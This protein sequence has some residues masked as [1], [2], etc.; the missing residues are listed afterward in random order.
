[1]R[2]EK[3]ETS[4]TLDPHGGFRLGCVGR[5]GLVG[6]SGHFK[7]VDK[8][9]S[10][11]Q[12]TI[13]QAIGQLSTALSKLS[14]IPSTITTITTVDL[15]LGRKYF[16]TIGGEQ[17]D[18]MLKKI[19]HSLQGLAAN[20]QRLTLNVPEIWYKN[21]PM[22]LDSL[23]SLTTFQS[24]ESLCLDLTKNC[25]AN[26]MPLAEALGSSSLAVLDLNLSQNFHI[27]D[28]TE[29]HT[30]LLACILKSSKL[31]KVSVNLEHN[32]LDD[33]SMLKALETT[34]CEN[35]RELHVKFDK[36][37]AVV[38]DCVCVC[39]P[40]WVVGCDP[41]CSCVCAATWKRGSKYLTD[42]G[43]ASTTLSPKYMEAPV[44]P[45]PRWDVW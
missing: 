24:L 17:N 16:M 43:A 35:L 19:A 22:P 28:A 41:P 5:V 29:R 37:L 10:R 4:V 6:Q 39:K 44:M 7:V 21:S 36:N 14:T 3:T 25:I 26:A 42:V 11:H 12:T 32:F 27:V 20:L 38:C 13:T 1:L 33:L 45:L 34:R 9:R 18:E 2:W 31:Q 8:V 23:I 15:T 30:E 40:P